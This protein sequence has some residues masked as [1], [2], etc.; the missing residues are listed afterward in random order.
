MKEEKR[1]VKIMNLVCGIMFFILSIGAVYAYFNITNGNRNTTIKV[2]GTLGN[3]NYVILLSEENDKNVKM[4]EKI[5]RV[6]VGKRIRKVRPNISITT[7][8][9][10]GFPQESKEDFAESI[11][12]IKKINFAKVHVFPYSKRD[13]TKAAR[14]TGH[15]DGIEKKERAKKLL[16]LSEDRV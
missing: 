15:I 6:E 2:R 1:K 12:F 13:G 4:L 9:I 16:E 7:D 8:V 10:V 11:E 5:D 3:P 14:M